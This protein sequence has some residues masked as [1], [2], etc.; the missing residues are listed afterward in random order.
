MRSNIYKMVF[1]IVLIY[2]TLTMADIPKMISHQG[3]ITVDG[4]NFSGTG[5]FKF[6]MVSS[7]GETVYWTNS[8]DENNDGVPDTP[9]SITVS[10]GLYSVLLGDTS[11]ENM[12][13]LSYS[14]FSNDSV[15]LRIWF[16]DGTSGSQLLVPDQRIASVGY[17]HQAAML[18]GTVYVD[19]SS[20]VGIGTTSPE[21]KVDIVHGDH[22][23]TYFTKIT[24]E[25][26]VYNVLAIKNKAAV[27]HRSS[28]RFMHG[29]TL[30]GRLFSEGSANE[31][32]AL[33]LQNKTNSSI[34]FQTNGNNT[35]M[36]IKGG[37]KIG[38]GK[39]SPS[40]DLDVNGEVQAT[41]FVQASDQRYKKN[42]QPIK[43]ALGI[44]QNVRG[45]YFD[46]KENP[47]TPRGGSGQQ[48]GFIGQEVEKVLPQLVKKDDRGYRAVSYSGF[49][50]VL[51]EALKQQQQMIRK[52]QK[53]I[54]KQSHAI[55]QLQEKVDRLGKGLLPEEK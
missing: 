14:V 28:L 27:G 6:A 39:E 23:E 22:Q 16:N 38:I 13:E 24:A 9:V 3:R 31:T 21:Y 7:D 48:V 46:W 19:S 51:L 17:A 55:I 44:I 32:A 50:P 53:L 52:Q 8:A 15:W 20:N 18:N 54:D 37:G 10:S 43:N 11:I 12:E 42:I 26:E 29:N 5:K 40:Y 4:T 45:V 30:M 25:E 36:I 2:C 35:R 34:S 47:A 41:A 1:G 49:T 33:T